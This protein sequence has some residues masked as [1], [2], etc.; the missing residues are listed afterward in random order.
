MPPT[1]T[2][3]LNKR[4]VSGFLVSQFYQNPIS[5]FLTDIDPISKIFKIILDRSS[6]FVGARLFPNC[7]TL[8]FPNIR[9]FTNTIFSGSVPG[10]FCL[11]SWRLQ[12]KLVSKGLDTSENPQIMEMSDFGFSHKQIEKLLYQIEAG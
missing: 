2:Q 7:Q 8:G 12:R 9:R 11:G 4:L 5:C 10:S 1:R 3:T 6:G